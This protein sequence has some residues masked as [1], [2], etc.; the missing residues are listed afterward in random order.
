MQLGLGSS[1]QALPREAVPPSLDWCAAHAVPLPA[2]DTRE[3][4]RAR[5][6]RSSCRKASMSGSASLR[7]SVSVPS[8][9]NK[10]ITFSFRAMVIRVRE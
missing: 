6:L 9:S 7:G 3:R 8:T 5:A 1:E 2:S 4:V 10:Q